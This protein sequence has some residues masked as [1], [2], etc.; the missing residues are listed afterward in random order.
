M[1]VSAMLVAN[2]HF[3]AFAG[4]LENILACWPGGREACMGRTSTLKEF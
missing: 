1:D 3:R 4:V 2:I